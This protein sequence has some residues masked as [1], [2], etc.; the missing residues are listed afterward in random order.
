M[1]SSIVSSLE[2][3]AGSICASAGWPIRIDNS[4]S[5]VAAIELVLIIAAPLSR[6]RLN[7]SRWDG[8]T[9]E[10]AD[11]YWAR[12]T[13]H[14]CTMQRT[15]MASF[16]RTNSKNDKSV[17][18]RTF[19]SRGWSRLPS[20][21]RVALA[22]KVCGSSWR[23]SACPVRHGPRSSFESQPDTG[24]SAGLTSMFRIPPVRLGTGSRRIETAVATWGVNSAMKSGTQRFA[25]EVTLTH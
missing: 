21:T 2:T 3:L 9:V 20:D 17:S 22:F 8:G 1:I 16:I 19:R 14:A 15:A 5:Q 7:G 25:N 6:K 12:A 13:I 10:G 18:I 23:N 24:V 4:S 11:R